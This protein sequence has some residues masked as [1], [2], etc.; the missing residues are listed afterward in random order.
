[1]ETSAPKRRM[2]ICLNNGREAIAHNRRKQNHPSVC[3]GATKYRPV[4]IVPPGPDVGHVPG[5][6]L[7]RVM[8]KSADA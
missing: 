7:P 5:D 4:E 1:M 2:L 8:M 3:G 6:T